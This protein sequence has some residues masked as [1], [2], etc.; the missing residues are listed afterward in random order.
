MLRIS[1]NFPGN[2]GFPLLFART[3]VEQL[4]PVS[5]GLELPHPKHVSGALQEA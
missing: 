2:K 4:L 5:R 1:S 3:V